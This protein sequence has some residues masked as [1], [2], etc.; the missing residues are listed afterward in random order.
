M[1]PKVKTMKERRNERNFTAVDAW[2]LGC[3]AVGS[4]V[5]INKTSDIL[6]KGCNKLIDKREAFELYNL[7]KGAFK[8]NGI[9]TAKRYEKFLKLLETERRFIENHPEQY[10]QVRMKLQNILQY[11][12]NKFDMDTGYY[13]ID[14]DMVQAAKEYGKYRYDIMSGKILDSQ[15]II[16]VHSWVSAEKAYEFEKEEAEKDLEEKTDAA[17]EAVKRSLINMGATDEQINSI[18]KSLDEC[19]GNTK[20]FK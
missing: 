1:F 18:I 14:E 2:V 15:D 4:T 12:E 3:Y 9:F 20:N 8:N 10:V 17:M 16:D 13:K 19:F 6:I 7:A 5:I 11:I